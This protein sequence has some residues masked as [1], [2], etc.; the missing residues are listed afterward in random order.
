[1]QQQQEEEEYSSD[2]EEYEENSD[3]NQDLDENSENEDAI[4]ALFIQF[5]K[6]LRSDHYLNFKA[7][8]TLNGYMD[9]K[10]DQVTRDQIDTCTL[11]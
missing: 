4:S 6:S 2:L 1:M 11:Y 5:E 9:K 7:P 10:I 3:E 8:Q